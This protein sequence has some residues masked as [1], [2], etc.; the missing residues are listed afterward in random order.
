MRLILYVCVVVH[1]LQDR[2]SQIERDAGKQHGF[3]ASVEKLA[4]ANAA[5]PTKRAPTSSGIS[6]CV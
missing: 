3:L 6:R 2:L 1:R 5:D 4:A